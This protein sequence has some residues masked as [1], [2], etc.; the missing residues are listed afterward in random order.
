MR[1]RGGR[2]ATDAGATDAGG[3]DAGVCDVPL[4][5][6]CGEGRCCADDARCSAADGPAR[7]LPDCAATPCP[8]DG[9]PGRRPARLR[10]RRRLP[11]G[12]L[13]RGRD[14]RRRGAVQSVR[15]GR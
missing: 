2:G 10:P 12:R 6:P 3:L 8:R 1:A 14:L 11:G 15:P 13:R 5:D 9:L 7:C 4:G